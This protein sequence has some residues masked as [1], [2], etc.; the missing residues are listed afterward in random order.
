VRRYTQETLD[1][2][3]DNAPDY[4]AGHGS[5]SAFP[6]LK[7]EVLAFTSSLPTGATVLDHGCGSGRDALFFAQAGFSVVALDGCEEFL[8]HIRSACA[9]HADRVRTML[10]GLTDLPF[11]DAAFDGV[12]S[13]AALVHVKPDGFHAAVREL[14]R[15]LRPG[16]VLALSL[17]VGPET[18]WCRSED[19]SRWFAAHPRESVLDALRGAAL[20]PTYVSEP[21][22]LNGRDLVMFRAETSLGDQ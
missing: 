4:V 6:G 7:D 15:V 20:A 18:R 1:W 9:D 8:G 19:D 14:G 11:P 12:W 17:V 13:C 10:A 16:G 21:T 3:R 2:Y 5:Y 22:A